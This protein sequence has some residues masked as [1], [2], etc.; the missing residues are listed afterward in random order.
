MQCIQRTLRPWHAV[1]GQ[2]YMYGMLIQISTSLFC[3]ADGFRTFI[4]MF[5]VILVVMMIVGHT[6]IRAYQRDLTQQPVK[7]FDVD[8][9]SARELGDLAAGDSPAI[10]P[11]RRW[12]KW[13][14]AVGMIIS[15]Q[16]LAGAGIM[17]TR[18]S[19]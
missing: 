9:S 6:A 17:F 1:I 3:R 16:Q 7:G 10:K 15:F 12:L 19:S 14:H 13:V 4:F 8:V 2:T 18:R 11:P 5:L